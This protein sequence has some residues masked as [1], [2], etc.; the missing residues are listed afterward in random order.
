MGNLRRRDRGDRAPAP[1]GRSA[2]A[3]PRLQRRRPKKPPSRLQI[4]RVGWWWEPASYFGNRPRLLAGC[5]SANHPG[6]I[7]RVS[8]GWA[9]GGRGARAWNGGEGW[10]AHV[11]DAEQIGLQP[12]QRDNHII[13]AV[14]PAATVR[15]GSQFFRAATPTGARARSG[16]H[17]A[18]DGGLASGSKG[19]RNTRQEAER[20][21][22]IRDRHHHHMVAEGQRRA[23]DQ[24][25][26]AVAR[27]Q[28]TA[29]DVDHHW[30]PRRLQRS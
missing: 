26:V 24:R 14:H 10:A 21:E 13:D 28:P 25:V 5:A 29:E 3:R 15:V 18:V 2:E 22:A 6:Q 27:A 8:V 16:G 7:P 30:Q 12:A 9:V 4:P 17:L 20:P 19:A 23:V 1:A 11:R